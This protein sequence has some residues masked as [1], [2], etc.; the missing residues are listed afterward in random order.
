MAGSVNV[1]IF[2]SVRVYEYLISFR[3]CFVSLE[4]QHYG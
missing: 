2:A 4:V 3:M 1:N